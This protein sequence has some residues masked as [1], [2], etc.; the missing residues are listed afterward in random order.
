T[1][2][3]VVAGKRRGL[4]QQL[5]AAARKVVIDRAA[6][7]AAVSEHVVDARGPRPASACR[8]RSRARYGVC[9]SLE[10]RRPRRP[11]ARDT[12]TARLPSGARATG[13][14]ASTNQGA[15]RTGE[16]NAHPATVRAEAEEPGIFRNILVSFDGSAH[17]QQALSEA[18]DLARANHARLTVL[19]AIP[20]PSNWS[21]TTP[22]GAAV[23]A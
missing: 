6:G 8:S 14:G 16:A 5:L 19:T 18:V 3:D 11:S 15:A 22:G 12:A 13:P 4:A 1:P 17:A 20:R 23:S 10:R 7:S 9:H 21:Y 2:S